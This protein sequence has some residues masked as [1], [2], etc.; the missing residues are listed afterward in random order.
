[1]ILNY[2]IINFKWRL[3]YY[4]F[5]KKKKSGE[6]GR[7]G[8]FSIETYDKKLFLKSITKGEYDLLK[9]NAFTLKDHIKKHS[10]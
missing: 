6:G 9:K 1:M 10:N 8:A 7:S 2:K 3:I 4:F 5:K